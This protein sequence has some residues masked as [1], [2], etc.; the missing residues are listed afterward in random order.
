MARYNRIKI[1]TLFLTDDGLVTGKPCKVEVLGLSRLKL[2]KTGTT[3]LSADGTPYQYAMPNEG[4]GVQIQI[5]PTTI[6]KSVFDDVI[7][8]MTASLDTNS[9]INIT[10]QG[11]TGDLDL[12]TTPLLPNGVDFPGSFSGGRITGVSFNFV[13]T[14]V[15]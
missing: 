3:R 13:I 15:N 5:R 10:I 2:S 1:G 11:D 8:E 6:V 14:E 7:D 12:E 4:K 9:T